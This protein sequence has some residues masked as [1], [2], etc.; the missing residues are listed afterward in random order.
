MAHYLRVVPTIGPPHV[1]WATRRIG[2]RIAAA[3]Q[4]NAGLDMSRLKSTDSQPAGLITI[5]APVEAFGASAIADLMRAADR[6][7]AQVTS[8]R[9]RFVVQ[10]ISRSACTKHG[11]VVSAHILLHVCRPGVRC[12]RTDV[13][14]STHRHR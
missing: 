9:R 13:D 8:S 14:E 1:G 3:H 5:G 12:S 11:L 6:W 7:Y 2:A 10:T 4:L